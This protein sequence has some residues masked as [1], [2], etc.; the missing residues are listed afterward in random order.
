MTCNG[1]CNGNSR[2]LRDDKQKDKQPQRQWQ[3]QPQVPFG[4]AQDG[5]FDS[6]T[7]K[8]ASYFAQDATVGL[9]SVAVMRFWVWPITGRG[10]WVS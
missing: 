5:F 6:V 3:E 7:H 10:S 1:H 9:E 4:F 2:S 8:C